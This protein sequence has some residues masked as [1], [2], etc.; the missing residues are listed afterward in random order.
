[1]AIDIGQMMTRPSD[2]ARVMSITCPNSYFA[3]PHLTCLESIPDRVFS[4]LDRL[5]KRSIHLGRNVDIYRLQSVFVVKEGLVFDQGA[6][7]LDVTRTYH[8]NEAIVDACV[9]V[10][11][12]IKS[13]SFRSLSRGILA[14]S[15][16]A[17]NYGHFLVEMLPRAWLARNRLPLDGWPAIIDSTSAV[18]QNVATQALRHAGFGADEVI[19]T[20][21]EPVFIEEL[22]VVDGLTSHTQYISPIVMQCLDAIADDVSS[23]TSAKIYPSRR[24]AV[25]RDFENEAE[26]AARLRQMGFQEM[27][28]G[29]LSFVEQ[30]AAFK[31]AEAV[32][33][34]S[35]A[36]LTNLVFCKPGTKVF[37]FTPAGAAEVLFWMIAESRRLQY[38]EIRCVETGPQIGGL[39]WNRALRI[40]ADEVERIVAAT[41]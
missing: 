35:G 12:A 8:E 30:I 13:T 22:I 20:G 10:Q 27:R 39:P 36:A 4:V 34:V 33:A 17:S 6:K 7:L 26:I 9:S 25:S 24:P 31:G 18:V 23:G 14:K 37:N 21:H 15:R 5:W 32:V 16:G 19:A 2:D 41:S 38:D 1:M 28:T 11:D 29:E 40:S 3:Y